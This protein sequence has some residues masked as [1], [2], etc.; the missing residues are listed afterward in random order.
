[1]RYWE[2]PESTCMAH[3][4]HD[5]LTYI[6]INQ[7]YY[8]LDVI[9]D[10]RK[11]ICESGNV[12]IECQLLIV[13]STCKSIIIF[14]RTSHAWLLCCHIWKSIDDHLVRYMCVGCWY[15]CNT[16]LVILIALC[17]SICVL[18]VFAP[19]WVAMSDHWA[20]HMLCN[21]VNWGWCSKK[22]LLR[23]IWIL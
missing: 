4:W 2:Y 23:D 17:V 18:F 16:S 13:S 5:Q 19:I 10:W 21:L 1:M 6:Q 3:E 22:L 14:V 20:M 11:M 7:V 9:E 12:I 15:Q 8:K